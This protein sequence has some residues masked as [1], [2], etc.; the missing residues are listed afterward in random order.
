MRSECR[1]ICASTPGSRI[2]PCA[3]PHPPGFVHCLYIPG[4]GWGL[5]EPGSDMPWGGDRV[6]P[7]GPPPSDDTIVGIPRHH[8]PPGAFPGFVARLHPINTFWEDARSWGI[9]S[10]GYP[11]SRMTARGSRRSHLIHVL[12]ILYNRDFTDSLEK[13]EN[14][15]L[16]NKI[17]KKYQALKNANCSQSR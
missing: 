12:F 3:H 11:P 10:L 1:S 8:S 9:P 13:R 2:I 15:Y 16:R 17:F 5:W 7:T 4:F 6:R 14:K